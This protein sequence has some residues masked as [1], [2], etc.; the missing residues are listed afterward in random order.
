MMTVKLSSC[1]NP[2]FGQSPYVP[3]SQERTVEVETLEEASRE[4]RRY[5]EDNHLGGGNWNGGQAKQGKKVVAQISYN[6]RIWPIEEW[7]RFMD[8][9]P[10]P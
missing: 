2:D 4:C 9:V 1:G 10:K 7:N 3:L 5:I 6:G 8:S